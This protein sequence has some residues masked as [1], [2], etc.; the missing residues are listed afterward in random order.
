MTVKLSPDLK[1]FKQTSLAMFTESCGISFTQPYNV[2]SECITQLC[3]DPIRI[4]TLPEFVVLSSVLG[5]PVKNGCLVNCFQAVHCLRKQFSGIALGTV[6]C[7]NFPNKNHTECMD[8]NCN[9]YH[10]LFIN[11]PYYKRCIYDIHQTCK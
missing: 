10:R 9:N 8:N 7:H 5:K 3:H 2:F 4:V 1:K 11:A 6:M